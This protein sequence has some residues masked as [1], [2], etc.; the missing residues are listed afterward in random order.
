MSMN[1]FY[2]ILAIQIAVVSFGLG[3]VVGLGL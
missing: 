3:I 1:K 2:F